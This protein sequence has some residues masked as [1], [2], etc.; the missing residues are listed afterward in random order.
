VEAPKSHD[1]ELTCPLKLG[2]RK[3]IAG[4]VFAFGLT[5]TM[6]VFVKNRAGFL[7]VRLML[8][9]TEAGYIPGSIYTLSTWYTPSEL[10]KKVAIFFFGMF[11]GNA[12]SPVLASG[13]LRLDGVQGLR[14]W[15]W[16]F[17]SIQPRRIWLD[18][19]PTNIF[20]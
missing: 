6:Q 18:R 13:I 5:A 11:G 8:G 15:Q 2:P 3:W 9:F 7:A 12:I 17:L 19:D 20:F 4:Q 10:A 14:G 16:L 1:V